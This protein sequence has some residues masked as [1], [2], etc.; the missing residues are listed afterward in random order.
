MT[1]RR[2]GAAALGS[3][4]LGAALVLS[5]GALVALPSATATQGA[6]EVP[7]LYL[8][9]LRGPGVTGAP[10]PE[11]GSAVRARLRAA[12]DATL[13]SVG[14][15]E[16]VYRWTEALNGYAV[17]LTSAQADLLAADAAVA[18][19]EPNEVRPLAASPA[20]AAVGADPRVPGSSSGRSRGGA[21]VVV[22]VVD[23]GLWPES[24]LFAGV[25]GLGSTPRGFRGGCEEGSD[26]TA[27]TCNR[28]VVGAR[29]F[30]DGF[31]TGNVRS[32]TSLSPRDDNGHG[33][34]V[35]S[36]AV[37]NADVSVR[38]SDEALGTFSGVAPQARIAVYKACWTAPDPADDGCASAD[39]VTAVDRAVE[40]G[41][42]VLNLSVAGPA[43]LDTL[44]RALLG[45][46]EAD[47]VVVAAAGNG[48]RSA[49]AAHASPWV[50][51]VGG[52]TTTLPRG[53]VRVGGGPTLEGAMVSRR[54]V[55]RSRIV[56]GARVAAPGAE[57]DDATLC[58]PGSLDAGQ[59]AGAIVVC[60]RGV[61]GRLDKSAA[62]A[63]AGGVAMVLTNVSGSGLALDL[64]LVPTVHLDRPA[65]DRLTAHLARHPRAR[66]TLRAS[67]TERGPVR[68]VR[69]SGGGD[70]ASA[71]VKP[72]LVAPAT[73]RLGSVPPRPD[74]NRFGFLS[75][76]SAASA[77]VSGVAALLRA[78][79]DDWSAAAIRSAL[80]TSARPLAGAALRQGAGRST[81]GAAL[82]SRLVLDVPAGDFR[83]W[84]DGDLRP[85][86]LNSASVLLDRDATV[87]RT[88]T[89]LGRRA[90]YYSSAARGFTRRSVTV[91]PA[92]LQV[93]P[94]GSAT[95]TVT[96]TGGLTPLDD[97]YVVWR[98][99]DGTRLR[100][101]VVLSR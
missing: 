68:V 21:G 100:L 82:R 42:D 89:N 101:P 12:Q 2:H 66:A 96:V 78:E 39:L 26:W 41:V 65:A 14:A 58:R 76:T 86:D 70:P 15:G 5:A 24:P 91:T 28:K 93:P 55:P 83:R 10:G 32:S 54:A 62:V 17:E 34:Q 59:V 61:I 90:M 7:G 72:D 99:A 29:W 20:V 45:A 16:P 1:T 25:P 51:T 92:A 84:L 18:L 22:G 43:G 38:G 80:T 4:V 48:G 85:A 52:T 31:G 56:L 81:I 49:Y 11:T 3:V 40:D 69:W 67:G 88:V 13:A 98:G 44:E 97:G 77:R 50:T 9:T 46:A 74:G 64:H 95:F 75:G 23:T 6:D 19:V 73:G 37:G 30:V 33:T 8:V 35:A 53:R 47:V 27:E 87:T 71:L 36:I 60:D 79:H 94:G 57:A 63:Q